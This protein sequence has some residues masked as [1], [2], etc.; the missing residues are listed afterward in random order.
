MSINV[1]DRSI[2]GPVGADDV[3]KYYCFSRYCFSSFSHY[4]KSGVDWIHP[5]LN[6]AI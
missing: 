5:L 2:P 4:Y 1:I 6:T 3:N